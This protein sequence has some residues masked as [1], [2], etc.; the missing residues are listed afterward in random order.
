MET[1]RLVLKLYNEEEES[2]LIELLTDKDVMKH[3]DNGVL[4]KENAAALWQK[5]IRDFYPKGIDTIYGV[6]SKDDERYVGHA[7]IR[8]RPEKK[9][10]WEIGYILRKEE[11][12]KGFATEIAKQLVEY[13]FEELNLK[14][15]FATIDDDNYG[16][17]KVAE[18]SGMS[19]SH[20]EYDE[21]GRFSVYSIKS[22]NFSTEKWNFSCEKLKFSTEEIFFS[23]EEIFFSSEEIKFSVEEMFFFNGGNDFLQ[24][25][26]SI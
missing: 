23:T 7:S 12:G 16:S 5:L 17:I 25:L 14:E 15:V 20:Y 1:E 19:F 24:S 11:W 10:D 4:T 13:G 21:Q 3:V 18:K 8:P 9:Q 6:F 2:L 22:Q 26:V